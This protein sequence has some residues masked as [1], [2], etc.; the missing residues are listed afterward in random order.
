MQKRVLGNEPQPGDLKAP[1]S[2][3]RQRR[4]R[5]MGVWGLAVVL[6]VLVVLVVDRELLNQPAF[7]DFIRMLLSQ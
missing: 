7:W 3:D 6:L 1:V 2:Q 5:L 4:R